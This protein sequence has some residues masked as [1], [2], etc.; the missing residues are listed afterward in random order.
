MKKIRKDLKRFSEF[1]AKSQLYIRQ[2]E[3]LG[4]PSYFAFPFLKPGI[5]TWYHCGKSNLKLDICRFIGFF[6]KDCKDFIVKII[7]IDIT[8]IS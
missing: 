5:S 2:V 4:V 7:P 3:L 6:D 1:Q 8:P